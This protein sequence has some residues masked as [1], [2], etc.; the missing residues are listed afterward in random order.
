MSK[1]AAKN[2]VSCGQASIATC[3]APIIRMGISLLMQA[4]PMQITEL[5]IKKRL[6]GKTVSLGDDFFKRVVVEYMMDRLH[7]QNIRIRWQEEHANYWVL[8][9]DKFQNEKWFFAASLVRVKNWFSTFW[10]TP[11]GNKFDDLDDAKIHAVF[12]LF[13]RD[14]S[15]VQYSQSTGPR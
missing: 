1:D 15:A 6:T 5:R 10:V 8:L 7:E 11:D 4:A 9:H 13:G 14:V 2:L 3:A 12:K